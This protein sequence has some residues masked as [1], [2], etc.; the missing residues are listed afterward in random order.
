MIQTKAHSHLA[1]EIL[2]SILAPVATTF[3]SS[4]A[5]IGPSIASTNVHLRRILLFHI[6]SILRLE[7]RARPALIRATPSLCTSLRELCASLAFPAKFPP[8][9]SSSTRPLFELLIL[10]LF[11][12]NP[13]YTS[14]CS[15]EDRLG[16]TPKK[17]LGRD[18]L[19]R[20]GTSTVQENNPL[21]P[22]PQ[23]NWERAQRIA[24]SCH[25][26]P[27]SQLKHLALSATPP[28]SHCIAIKC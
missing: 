11:L 19:I 4:F 22:S 25:R 2:P 1:A 7:P 16:I 27:P 23:P 17:Y 10:R 5:L 15:I 9:G 8:F 6:S 14:L 24:P 28:P 21:W 26:V 18:L 20:A 13:G 12:P 3:T